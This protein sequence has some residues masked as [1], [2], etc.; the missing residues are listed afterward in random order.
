[1]S[2]ASADPVR[3]CSCLETPT[4][5]Y[6]SGSVENLR[7]ATSTYDTLELLS[8]LAKGAG[9]ETHRIFGARARLGRP[10]HTH[11]RQSDGVSL[12]VILRSTIAIARPTRSQDGG[13]MDGRI[14]LVELGYSTSRR[15]T[16]R[17]G[18][19]TTSRERDQAIWRRK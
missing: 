8:S 16:S 11:V 14:Q 10:S 15:S 3:W 17:Y 4:L 7:L 19:R 13:D 12:N 9:P 6:P 2:H 5:D 18:T 1:M